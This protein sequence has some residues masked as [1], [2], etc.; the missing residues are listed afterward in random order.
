M[1][2][3]TLTSGETS[4]AALLLGVSPQLPDDTVITGSACVMC[5]LGLPTARTV[6]D[7]W[8]AGLERKPIQNIQPTLLI[9]EA[10]VCTAHCLAGV[11]HLFLRYSEDD[12]G[13]K[14]QQRREGGQRQAKWFLPR[15]DGWQ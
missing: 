13:Y 2:K 12:W 10:F 1:C 15:I 4:T 5:K 3:E 9:L 11:G 7:V 14:L 6:D 8:V